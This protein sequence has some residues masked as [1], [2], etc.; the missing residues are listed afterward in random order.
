MTN[1]KLSIIVPTYNHEK[2][3]EECI[4]SILMQKMK[5]NYEVLIGED[6]SKD[7]T[8]MVLKKLENE[9]PHNYKI[10]YREKNMGMGP[11]G[12]AW[13]LQNRA[14]G[15]YIISIEGDDFF[16]DEHKLQKQVDFLDKH[17]EFI[18]VAHNCQVV[19]KNSKYSLES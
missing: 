9:I 16:I 15:E 2:Y 8:A 5:F 6:C 4:R 7:K 10:F 18:A 19:D 13:D 11:M 17:K 14:K 12:N 3:I 1:V